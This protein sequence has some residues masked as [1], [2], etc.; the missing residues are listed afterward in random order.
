[1]PDL[2]RQKAAECR[3][4]EWHE[5]R[6][7]PRDRTIAPRRRHFDRRTSSVLPHEE[8]G[9]SQQ[10]QVMARLIHGPSDRFLIGVAYFCMKFWNAHSQRSFILSQQ[11][12]STC[13]EKRMQAGLRKA[14]SLRSNILSRSRKLTPGRPERCFASMEPI[15]RSSK[16]RRKL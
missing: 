5:R 7:T 12:V 16:T 13:K 3:H 11:W 8:I 10:Q 1:V 14:R 9:N 2:L 4:I 6:G 15:G